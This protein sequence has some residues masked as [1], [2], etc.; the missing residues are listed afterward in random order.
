MNLR[1]MDF[2]KLQTW[3]QIYLVRGENTREEM[4]REWKT[5]TINQQR[6]TPNGFAR[7]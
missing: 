3:M 2:L 4:V 6:A 5:G 7:M 1:N